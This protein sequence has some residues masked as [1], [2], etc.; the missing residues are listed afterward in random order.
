MFHIK[1]EVEVLISAIRITCPDMNFSHLKTGTSLIFV[2]LIKC[3]SL[4]MQKNNFHFISMAVFIN[5][6]NVSTFNSLP[7]VLEVV[8]SFF[9]LVSGILF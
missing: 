8:V 1:H 9:F 5:I 6:V 2:Q 3:K 4:S 7:A